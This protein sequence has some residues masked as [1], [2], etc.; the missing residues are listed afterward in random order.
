MNSL[1]CRYDQMDVQGRVGDHTECGAKLF[2]S[3]LIIH[4]A[5][6]ET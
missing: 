6:L 1:N 4:L 3:K 5:E 2:L